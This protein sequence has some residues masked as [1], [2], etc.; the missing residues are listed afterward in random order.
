MHKLKK[1]NDFEQMKLIHFDLSE[2]VE[3][4]YTVIINNCIQGKMK[5]WLENAFLQQKGI[6]LVVDQGKELLLKSEDEQYVITAKNYI[7]EEWVRYIYDIALAL[8][9]EGEAFE[10]VVIE[11]ELESQKGK[12]FINTIKEDFG[13]IDKNCQKCG[14]LL[15]SLSSEM[16][17]Y[18]N[19]VNIEKGKIYICTNEQCASFDFSEAEFK[20]LDEAYL[21]KN[22]LEPGDLKVIS[23]Y[24]ELARKK[25]NDELLDEKTTCY[26]CS[27]GLLKINSVYAYNSFGEKKYKAILECDFCHSPVMLID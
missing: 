11:S 2:Y 26:V 15:G 22:V 18:L 10:Q 9:V 23:G 3:E 8:E 20:S 27:Q 1:P 6:S 21:Q 16:E 13:I 7:E 24:K 12:D 4:I 14:H 5:D 19:A 17:L 25:L